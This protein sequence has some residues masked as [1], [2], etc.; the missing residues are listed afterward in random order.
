MLVADQGRNRAGN[1]EGGGMNCADD[2][3]DDDTPLTIPDGGAG[4]LSVL[5]CVLLF[6][7]VLFLCTINYVSGRVGSASGQHT[8][9]PSSTTSACACSSSLTAVPIASAPGLS[10][11]ETSS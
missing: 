4:Y 6:C 11:L 5:V 2:V 3:D 8:R 10:V 1:D 9:N 7:F